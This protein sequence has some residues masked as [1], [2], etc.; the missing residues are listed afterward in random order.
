MTSR[1]YRSALYVPAS[2]P[3]AMEKARDLAADAVIFDL[4]DAV[5]PDGKEAARSGLAGALGSH[6]YAGRSR[7][8]RINALT[9]PW[10]R[11]D[12]ALLRECP[13]DG[14]LV[15][16]VAGRDHLE[17]LTRMLPDLPVW[18]MI[19]TPAGVLNAADIASH[20]QVVGLVAGTND[21]ARDL[22][23]RPGGDRAPLLLALQSCVL[24]ARSVGKVALDGVLNRISDMEALEAECRQGR[25]LGFD[26]KT[27][28]H[29]GQL[30][31]ANRIF[32]PSEEEID[33]AERRIAAH[34]AAERDGQGVAVLDGEIVEGLHVA[35]ARDC[36]A[37]AASIRALET[38][39]D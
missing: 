10:G 33:L 8:V 34:E 30:E 16:K 4:E 13:C 39:G 20:P 29:P 21:L 1:P 31:V 26:G 35:A 18:A 15:P 9:S 23:A 25:D 32:A 28:I 27:V 14:V 37:R 7:I 17:A 19:E 2:K 11:A 6:D 36:L 38:T 22:G 24:A 12:A 3:R 5:S